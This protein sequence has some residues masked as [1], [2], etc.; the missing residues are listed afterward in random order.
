[1][2]PSLPEEQIICSS[3]FFRR[4]LQLVAKQD[5]VDLPKLLT[6]RR[7]VFDNS[8]KCCVL[9]DVRPATHFNAIHI[10]GSINIPISKLLKRVSQ[11]TQLLAEQS[12]I[13]DTGLQVKQELK[14][15]QHSAPRCRNVT[16]SNVARKIF[17]L[18]LMYILA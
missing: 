11:L 9:L 4:A 13:S 5:S 18:L 3:A 6:V 1:M 10:D 15:V 17:T 16:K 8:E 12:T 14:I 2:Y 7:C